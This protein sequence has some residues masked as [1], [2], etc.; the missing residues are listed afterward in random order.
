MKNLL[1]KIFCRHKNSEVV[2][3]HWTHGPLTNDIR[4]LEIQFKC[5]DCGRYYFREIRDWNDCYKFIDKYPDKRWSN[6]CK[7]V[8][9]MW[10]FGGK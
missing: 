2:C 8:L 9:K 10:F 5:N 3:W 4:Y 1:K 7:P 6:T